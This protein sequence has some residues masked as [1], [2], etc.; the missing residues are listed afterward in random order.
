MNRPDASHARIYRRLLAVYP[1]E[2]RSRYEDEMVQLF[3]DQLRDAE[4]VAAADGTARTWLRAIRDLVVTALSERARTGRT[5]G[6]SLPAGPSGSSR[7]LGLLGILGGVLLVAAFVPNL[8]WTSDL[9]NLRLVLFNAGAISV[10]IAVHRRQSAVSRR[11]SAAVVVPVVLANAWYLAMIVVGLGRPG[12]PEPDPDFR[13][14]M[15]FAGAAMWWADAAFGLVTWRLRT[16]TRWGALALAI[17]SVLA[18]IGMDRLELVR[19]D[20]AWLFTPIALLGIALNGV[21]WILLG[22]DLAFRRRT[23][24]VGS[25]RTSARPFE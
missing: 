23:P 4:T 10:S 11:V 8:P 14:V 6:H 13:L 15:F 7:L 20:L 21:G 18:F 2:F 3:V 17:G 5:V 16:V 25:G 22:V 12:F 9:F 1:P 24:T 19:G